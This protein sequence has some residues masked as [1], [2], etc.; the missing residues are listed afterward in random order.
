M[1]INVA[2]RIDQLVKHPGKRGAPVEPFFSKRV[3]IRKSSSPACIE[4][5]CRVEMLEPR[6]FLSNSTP[7]YAETLS[8]VPSPSSLT[9]TSINDSEYKELAVNL[10]G[11]FYYSPFWVFADALKMESRGFMQ[12]EARDFNNTKV[13]TTQLD[14]RGYVIPAGTYNAKPFQNSYHPT[15]APT[16]L[17]TVTWV[18]DGTV[19]L[20]RSNGTELTPVETGPN[21][22][23]YRVTDGRL[24]IQVDNLARG[25]DYV[26]DV[27]V[28]MPDPDQPEVRSLEP[29]SENP[30][31]FWHPQ[32]IRHLQEISSKASY[33][34][35]MDWL[36]TNASP[37]VNWSDRRPA[38]HA[39]ANGNT[40]WKALN[41]PGINDPNKYGE[42]GVPWEWIIDLSNRLNVNP[43]INIPHA[44]NDDYI[45]NVAR[46]FAGKI[47][48]QPG[49]NPGLKLYI[50]HSNEIWSSGTEFAQGDWAT[51][52]SRLLGI[53]KPAFNGRRA[54]EMFRIF[55]Q[56]F[57]SAGLSGNIDRS[58]DI[59]R[60][61][62]AFS[63]QQYYNNTYLTAM[64][65]R[66]DD[67]VG[68]PNYMGH[69]LAVTTYFGNN[70]F[71]KHLFNEI[72]WL[73]VNYGDPNDPRIQQAIDDWITKFSLTAQQFN[74]N[75]HQ[76]TAAAFGLKYLAYEGG[77]S[78]Y[79]HGQWVYIKDGKI[80]DSTTPGATRNYSLSEYVKQNYPD[81]DTNPYNNDRFTKFIEEI[82]RNPRMAEVYAAQ[83]Q[84]Y[85]ARGLKTHAAFQD[86]SPWNRNGQWGHK[87]YLGQTNGYAYGQA[88]KWQYLLDYADEEQFIRDID[89]PINQ[90]PRLPNNS[91]IGSIYTGQ[92]FV[93][94]INALA[95]GDVANPSNATFKLVA[96]FV[97]AGMTLTR[98]DDD[99]MRLSGVALKPGTY[100]MMLRLTDDDQDPA[101][102]IYTLEVS[103]GQLTTKGVVASDDTYATRGGTSTATHGTEK[104]ILVGSGF[105]TGYLKFDLRNRIAGE[106]DSAKLRVY[107]KGFED[108]PSIPAVPTGG[109]I[110]FAQA[111]DYQKQLFGEPL[112]LWSE[113]T[114]DDW[115]AH[116][117]G[118]N[119]L[120]NGAI[121]LGANPQGWIEVDVTNYVKT[122]LGDDGFI[123]FAMTGRVDN[124]DSVLSGIRV[125]SKEYAGGDFAP[126]LIINQSIADTLVPLRADVQPISPNPRTTALNTA[127]VVF[128]RAVNGFGADD[129]ILTKNGQPVTI[130]PAMISVSTTN[131]T[132]FTISGLST[133][134]A[135]TGTYGL[136][137]RV[138]GSG[139][140]NI[141]LPEDALAESDTETWSMI[142]PT[143]VVGRYVFYNNSSFDGNNPQANALDNAA[144][145]TDKTALRPGQGRANF[146][147]YTNYAKGINGI[148]IDLA[149]L[150]TGTLTEEDLAFKIGNVAS[151]SSMSS[152]L[153]MPE[154]TIRH[155]QGVNGSDRITLIWPDGLIK[156]T[157]LQVTLKATNNTGLS[158]PDVFY[159]GNIVG[160][161]GNITGN[162]LVNALDVSL[163]TANFSG[164]NTVGVTNRFDLNRDGRVDA[165]DLSI[166]TANYSGRTLVQLINV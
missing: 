95:L 56:E 26:R 155:G 15:G 7:L 5:F 116:N 80:V 132:T 12:G 41:V 87:E 118:T 108:D 156:N 63:G 146:S 76:Q 52:Q 75:Q 114:L 131:N 17:Y 66:A 71:V 157:W 127:T 40:N 112:T 38:D 93:Y 73:N 22:R 86:I 105:R 151:P 109:A 29:T 125:A 150:P 123:S 85:K 130:N 13:P 48:G 53:T 142:A 163:M 24:R 83:L 6:R 117:P 136:S 94:D 89:D 144:I 102:G 28:W 111:S 51:E 19:T 3:S 165:L 147:H 33:F 91:V 106:I 65:D 2:V 88:I 92:S 115:H 126:Q 55:D 137:V 46:M 35:F 30:N 32:Y 139:I 11:I 14:S 141:N 120:G 101:Y 162:T 81:D 61:A 134:T 27:H 166:V 20:R 140:V 121:S 97:P 59:V 153:T 98:L 143:S 9:T 21:R 45:R 104:D 77:P 31:P 84:V 54:T 149:N 158:N 36:E 122:G 57:R 8:P 107:I 100:R 39:F 34:R 64:Q 44:A 47:P 37:Q 68:E 99:T 4:G 129:I 119:L 43:W 113:L 79:T 69:V 96:G 23:V 161:S 145:A 160:E 67:W 103:G 72:D 128:N 164:R 154:I 82:N 60:V 90:V 74:P 10:G 16:G 49:L 78:L 1:G 18:G 152:L 70:T 42:I 124:G 110:T 138:P 148:I 25:G 159:F 50:E 62:A 133:Y 58:S 135:G